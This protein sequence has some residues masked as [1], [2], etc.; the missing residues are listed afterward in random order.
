V[1]HLKDQLSALIDGE[2]SGSEL[3]RAH[4][5]LASCAQCRAEAAALR[6][7]KREL[8]NLAAEQPSDDLARRLLAMATH[9]DAAPFD[10]APPRRAAS[11][12][13]SP[14]T[15]L[16]APDRPGGYQ[17]PSAKRPVGSRPVP[18]SPGDAW[19]RRRRGRALAWG[20]L[21]FVVTVGLGAAAI[22]L[23]DSPGG[24]F[25]P[26]MELFS[27]EHALFNGG[28]PLLDPSPAPRDPSPFQSK[29]S[30]VPL[31]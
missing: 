10:A 13:P 15:P 31:P 29:K 4:A 26:Q 9:D 19:S 2:L 23:G 27:V 8:R 21:S 24:R 22:S 3:D 20:A 11:A 12:V 18:R 28:V 6:D 25:T 16:R 5:H 7:L 30:I 1:S 17:Q 14:R